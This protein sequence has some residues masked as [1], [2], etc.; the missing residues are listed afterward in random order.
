MV[1][2][3]QLTQES[4]VADI[5]SSGWDVTTSDGVPHVRAPIHA[6]LRTCIDRLA[7]RYRG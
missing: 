6:S 4:G 1:E 2:A 7:A 5:D 3:D